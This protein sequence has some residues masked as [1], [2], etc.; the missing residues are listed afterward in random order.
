MGRW[1]HKKPHAL[2]G[3]AA[4]SE[5]RH[6]RRSAGGYCYAEEFMASRATQAV[7]PGGLRSGDSYACHVRSKCTHAHNA[8]RIPRHGISVHDS[9]AGRIALAT[10][11]SWQANDDVE[12]I[13]T[14]QRSFRATLPGNCAAVSPMPR[15]P[16]L[17]RVGLAL[18]NGGTTPI[19]FVLI[20]AHCGVSEAVFAANCLCERRLRRDAGPLD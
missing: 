14:T 10:A 7:D 8:L 15:A 12:V 1:T 19:D 5:A 9:T 17:V 2:K 18:V 16:A 20:D 13:S 4:R 11:P 6:T 3:A